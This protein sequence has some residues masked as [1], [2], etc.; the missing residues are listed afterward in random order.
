MESFQETFVS[1]ATALFTQVDFHVL[2]VAAANVTVPQASV[3]LCVCINFIPTHRY[4]FHLA[5]YYFNKMAISNEVFHEHLMEYAGNVFNG[6]WFCR[7]CSRRTPL[8]AVMCVCVLCTLHRAYIH[9][10][11]TVDSPFSCHA[12][13]EECEDIKDRCLWKPPLKVWVFI[14]QNDM[15]ES[16]R[17]FTIHLISFS[18]CY[19]FYFDRINMDECSKF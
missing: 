18:F 17:H 2:C 1:R 11:S 16:I 9:T 5:Q 8:Y 10:Y 14:I 6:I 4:L 19:Y 12:N 3:P 13:K 7:L 15:I